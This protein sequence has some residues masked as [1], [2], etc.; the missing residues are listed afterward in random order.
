[1]TDA[2]DTDGKAGSVSP[3]V[4]YVTG[5]TRGIGRAIAFRLAREGYRVR[6]CG[7]TAAS[8]AELERAAGAE[9]LDV[10]GEQVDVCDPARLVAALDHAA[11][12]GGGLRA[13]VCAAGMPVRGT[14]LELSGEDWDRCLDLNLKAMFTACQAAL[15]HL[16]RTGGGS[17]VCISSIWAHTTTRG[18]VAYI[19]AKTAI[20]GLVRALALD[21]AGEGV[22]VNAVAPGF[23]ETDLLRSSL[24]H[25]GKDID[26]EIARIQRLHPLGSMVAPEDIADAVAFLSG[27]GARSITGQTLT[28]DGGVS[29]RFSLNDARDI[30]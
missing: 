4:A 14:A 26:A 22:R 20:S 1:M 6:A 30:V 19:T 5:G 13:L 24:A 12:A 23:V 27:S 8:V 11:G 3:P 25:I 15:P 21:H 29:M 28:V 18:R 2:G 7:S 9:S 16:A 10:H 17:I